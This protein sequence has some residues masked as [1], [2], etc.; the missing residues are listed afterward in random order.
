[1]GLAPVVPFST[2]F[3]RSI[4]SIALGGAIIASVSAALGAVS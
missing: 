4:V 3:V 1:V 2:G